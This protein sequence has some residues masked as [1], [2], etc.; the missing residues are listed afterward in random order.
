MPYDNL[1]A[2]PGS[3]KTHK[4]ASLTLEQANKLAEIYDAIKEKGDV[5]NAVA[6][7]W[8]Q[9]EKMYELKDG[10]WGKKAPKFEFAEVADDGELKDTEILSMGTWKGFKFTLS[11]LDNIVRNFARI[12]LRVPLKLGHGRQKFAQNEGL[13]AVGWVKDLKRVG[14]KL[15]ATFGDIPAKLVELI[16]RKNYIRFSSE[17]RRGYTHEGN[18]YG[19]VLSGVALLGEEIPAVQ[20]ISD[21]YDLHNAAAAA[22]YDDWGNGE[23]IKVYNEEENMNELQELQAK[24]EAKEK[25]MQTLAEGNK[26]LEQQV[27]SL[28]EEQKAFNAD[29]KKREIYATLDKGIKEMKLAP[30]ARE[31][32]AAICFKAEGLIDEAHTHT[33]A[34]GEKQVELKINSVSE[35]LDKVFEAQPK[36][37]KTDESSEHRELN[38]EKESEQVGSKTYFTDE[39][40]HEQIQK[41]AKEHSMSYS[42]ATEAVSLE[43]MEKN[44]QSEV[45]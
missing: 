24:L 19:N 13:P 4:G 28:S 11:D 27:V 30:A 45:N 43:L 23:V 37:L 25:E 12:S 2:V 42:E 21:I 41:Y 38:S 9:W 7:A 5:E 15:F 31:M 32:L 18:I 35:V 3:F 44:R 14:D 33:F 17:V 22:N 29:V 34:E 36:M 6:V 1:E 40:L 39:A 16:K 20:N 8:A 10:K 26:K